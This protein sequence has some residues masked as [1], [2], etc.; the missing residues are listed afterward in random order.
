[1]YICLEEYFYVTNGR[2][3]PPKQ[4]ARPDQK[5]CFL[6][7]LTALLPD[8]TEDY[9]NSFSTLGYSPYAIIVT[10]IIAFLSMIMLVLMGCRKYDGTMSMVSTNSM[11]ISA[12][13]HSLPEDRELGNQLPV[14]WGVKA[15]EDVV[16]Q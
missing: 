6:G 10:G 15:Q 2:Y 4:D 12:A 8:G 16:Y 3:S 9:R 11:A 5:R 7:Q 1:Y 13:C 14:Q